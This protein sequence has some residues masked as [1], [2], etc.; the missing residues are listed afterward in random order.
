MPRS[1]EEQRY[2]AERYG[3]RH[4]VATAFSNKR[5]LEVVVKKLVADLRASTVPAEKVR[6]LLADLREHTDD[7]RRS[8]AIWAIVDALE[9]VQPYPKEPA[10]KR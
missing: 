8:N 1:R 10:S 3:R 7:R 5:N 9:S 4:R 6:Q 2:R